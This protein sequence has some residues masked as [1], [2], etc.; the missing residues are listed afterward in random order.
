[1]MFLYLAISDLAVSGALIREDEDVK[2]PIYYV[3][4][5]MNGPHTKG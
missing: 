1:M 3:S 4:H 5:S 2:K